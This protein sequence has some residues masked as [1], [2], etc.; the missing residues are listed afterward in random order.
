MIFL[1]AQIT[2]T[3]KMTNLEGRPTKTILNRT[4][5]DKMSASMHF[6]ETS[7]KNRTL[8]ALGSIGRLCPPNYKAKRAESY[9]LRRLAGFQLPNNSVSKCGKYRIK[10]ADI[11]VLRS[12][13]NGNSFYANLQQ[14]GLIWVCPVCAKKITE[15]RKQEVSTAL[16]NWQKEGNTILFLTLTIPHYVNQSC[17]MVADGFSK[18]RR[19]FWNDDRVK[20]WRKDLGV[21]GYI[22]TL[23]STYGKNGFHVHAHLAL[24]VEGS[25]VSSKVVNRAKPVWNRFIQRAGYKPN[26]HSWDIQ[27]ADCRIAGYLA[28]MDISTNWGVAEEMAKSHM[29]TR[30]K[31]GNISVWEL[32]RAGGE[33]DKWAS[34]KWIDYT[35]GMFR[36]SFCRFSPGLRAIVLPNDEEELTDSEVV[37][38]QDDTAYI[39]ALIPNET[40]VRIYR[41]RIN[42]ELLDLADKGS[43]DGI[44][45]LLAVYGIPDDLIYPDISGQVGGHGEVARI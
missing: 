38:R 31:N 21:I 14:C 23:E 12:K 5:D 32:C 43:Q 2:D 18:I 34:E 10:K 20:Q 19:R 25:T 8:T 22:T 27:I 17:K 3:D 1:Q 37:K 9:A 15:F 6:T 28:K 41:C 16:Q 33:G 42:A 39:V 44:R 13:T 45:E 40:W 36:K 7:G 11:K 26:K 30:L 4:V 29:K 24:F 35:K